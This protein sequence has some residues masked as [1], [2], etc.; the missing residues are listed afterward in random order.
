MTSPGAREHVRQTVQCIVHEWGFRY[1]K[2][3]G[4]STGVG[5]RPQYVNTSY[6]DDSLGEGLLHDPD[7]SNIEAFRDGLRLV[8][9]TAGQKVF[10]LGCCTPQNMRSYGA[11]GR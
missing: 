6:K 2:M 1:L 10:I 4:L 7:K 11:G 8:R 3:D 9:E 5:V